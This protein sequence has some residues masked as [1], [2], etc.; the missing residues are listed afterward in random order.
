MHNVK[1][2]FFTL[3]HVV[4]YARIQFSKC[5][6]F[7]FT[8]ALGIPSHTVIAQQF[9]SPTFLGYPNFEPLTVLSRIERTTTAVKCASNRA[10]LAVVNPIGNRR[11]AVCSRALAVR[12]Q[13]EVKILSCMQVAR[14]KFNM[15]HFLLFS[16]Q[17]FI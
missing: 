6:P 16:K 12:E 4:C 9:F 8:L 15:H 13:M 7:P 14:A 1:C 3:A 17:I 10:A 5:P 11:G 2:Q